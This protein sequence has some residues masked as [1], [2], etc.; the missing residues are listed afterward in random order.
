[1]AK[2][3]FEIFEEVDVR[4]AHLDEDEYENRHNY[5]DLPF[6]KKCRYSRRQ[7]ELNEYTDGY[8]SVI[9]EYDMLKLI[10]HWNRD[11]RWKYTLHECR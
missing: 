11:R 3:K 5:R 1:M 4:Y 6:K 2:K 10:N 8:M 7:L 9:N